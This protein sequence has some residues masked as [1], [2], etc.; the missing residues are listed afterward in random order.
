M[1]SWLVRQRLG[2]DVPTDLP[3]M[4]SA[5]TKA[6]GT[7]YSSYDLEFSHT[8]GARGHFAYWNSLV[9]CSVKS[10]IL[11]N[12]INLLPHG[13]FLSL[14]SFPWFPAMGQTFR[15]GRVS[16][17]HAHTQEMLVK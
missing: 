4:P 17:V 16:V 8:S 9:N 5:P 2:H 7:I 14:Q 10:R 6:L 15:Q 12:V 3:L 11:C 13:Y 1:A